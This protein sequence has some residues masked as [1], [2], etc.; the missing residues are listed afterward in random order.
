M[1]FDNSFSPKLRPFMIVSAP[2]IDLEVNIKRYPSGIP[3]RGLFMVARVDCNNNVLAFKV[4]SQQSKFIN[5]Y[6]YL[7]SVKHH[8]FL[9]ADSYV[10]LDKWHTLSTSE[11]AIV[12]NVIPSLRMAILRKYDLIT[13]DVD[14]SLKDNMSWGDTIYVSPNKK[15]NYCN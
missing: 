6:T 4:T 11:C 3:Q 12:G 2:Y 1:V 14:K 7:I 15:T 9:K 8:P 13:R 10:Q 5:E